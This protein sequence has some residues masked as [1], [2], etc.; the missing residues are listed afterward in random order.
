L[1]ATT[2]NYEC[3]VIDNTSKSNRLEDQVYWYK[4]AVHEPFTIGSRELWELHNQ[5]DED[6]Q[7]EELFD[8][9]QYK[10]KKNT[11]P[12]SVKKTY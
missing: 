11:P 5:C 1:D 10:K 2:E 7:E 12:L 8:I 4:A 9:T 6:E 3:L